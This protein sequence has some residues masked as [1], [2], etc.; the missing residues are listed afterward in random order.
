MSDFIFGG[1]KITADSDCSHDPAARQW[2]GNTPRGDGSQPFAR[3][4]PGDG[5][6]PFSRP[7]GDESSG[8]YAGTTVS[9]KKTRWPLILILLGGVAALSA[10]IGVYVSKPNGRPSS[11]QVASP[12]DKGTT[13]QLPSQPSE[14]KPVEPKP[15]ETVAAP[16]VDPSAKQDVKIEAPTSATPDPKNVDA[17]AVATKPEVKKTGTTRLAKSGTS[18]S[19][20]TATPKTDAKAT[21][22]AA[23]STQID[24]NAAPTKEPDKKAPP[25]DPFGSMHGCTSK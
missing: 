16:V 11:Q 20:K 22:A 21:K 18:K 1:S 17:K 25:C 3:P 13:V 10:G 8:A 19:A 12:E 5:S 6:Q 9:L 24:P 23:G 7:L 2:H 14:T 15:A 4:L